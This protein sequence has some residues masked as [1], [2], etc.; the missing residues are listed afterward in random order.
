MNNNK[1]AAI[2]KILVITILVNPSLGVRVA[3]ADCLDNCWTIITS[4]N[5]GTSNNYLNGVAAVS[6]N[7]VWAVGNYYESSAAPQPQEQKEILHWNGVSWSTVS[8]PSIGTQSFLHAI[9][10]IS[11]N[12]VW[13]VGAYYAPGN[14]YRTLI[15]HWDGTEWSVIPS[16]NVGTDD[17]LLRGIAG[18]SSTDMWAVGERGTGGFGYRT[19]TMHWDGTAWEVIDSPNPGTSDTLSGVTAV[20]STNV[21]AVGQYATNDGGRSLTLQWTGTQ[22][23]QRDS[24]NPNLASDLHGV[25]AVSADDIW[26]VG[27]TYVAIDH[28]ESLMLHW[29]GTNWTHVSSPDVGS[30]SEDIYGVAR[31]AASNVWAVGW[32]SDGGAQRTL[33]LHWDGA[34]WNH[35]TSSN[36]GSSSYSN[37]L[38]AV[39][40]TLGGLGSVAHIWTVG[41]YV[42]DGGRNQTLT[43]RYVLPLP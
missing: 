15:M 33:S 7:D 43:E 3:E 6:T 1:V 13:A 40:V 22:W 38:T 39:A 4:P 14:R 35:V 26:A 11:A 19:L 16:P 9:T 20:S 17:N 32:Y 18:V 2:V 34:S 36:V 24:P 42:N 21:W 27:R 25:S 28:Y 8:S 10:A 37:V 31:V 5:I 41:N 23:I 12:D 29:N 30:S